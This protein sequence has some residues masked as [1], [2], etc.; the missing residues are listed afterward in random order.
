MNTPCGPQRFEA[1]GDARCSAQASYAGWSPMRWS[2]ETLCATMSKSLA[3][4]NTG[5]LENRCG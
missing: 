1:M 5:E 4:M 2:T 3:E